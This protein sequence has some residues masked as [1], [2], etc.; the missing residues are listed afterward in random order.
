MAKIPILMYHHI[1]PV[2]EALR[3]HRLSNLYVPP[4]AFESQMRLLKR[5]GFRGLS[6]SQ[7]GPHLRGEARGRVVIITLDDGYVDNLD[8]ALP[9]LQHHGFSATCYPVSAAPGGYDHWNEASTGM[10]EPLMNAIQLRQWIAAGMEVGAHTRTH[11]HL[12]QCDDTALH[13]EIQTCKTELEDATGTA[14]TQFC[15]PYG[16]HDERVV[17]AVREAGYTDATTTVRGRA[18]PGGDRLRWPR[19]PIKNHHRL[20]KIGVRV[21]TGL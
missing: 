16:D 13:K 1:A 9:I 21:L 15:Y 7:A 2:P 20:P 3:D 12:T 17:Q 18:R 5:L 10:R 4:Q 6:M 14:V 8:N 11:P 19:I